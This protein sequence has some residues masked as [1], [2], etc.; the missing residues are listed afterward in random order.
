[1]KIE[2]LFIPIVPAEEE[3]K[4]KTSCKLK[5]KTSVI[6]LVSFV[7]L[8]VELKVGIGLLDVALVTLLQILGQDNISVLADSVHTGLLTD[9]SNLCSRQLVRSRHNYIE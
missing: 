8:L 5:K 9:S 3:N 7:A 4:V 6:A 2:S 1:M